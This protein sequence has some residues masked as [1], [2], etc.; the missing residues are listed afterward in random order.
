MHRTGSVVLK[1]P[2]SMLAVFSSSPTWSVVF[3]FN[4][5][6]NIVKLEYCCDNTKA[7]NTNIHIKGNCQLLLGVHTSFFIIKYYFR[8]ILLLYYIMYFFVCT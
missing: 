7:N 8:Y 4:K 2:Y 3:F 6:K 5:V 1:A